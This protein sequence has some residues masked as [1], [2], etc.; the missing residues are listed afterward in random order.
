MAP[1]KA[2]E[3]VILVIGNAGGDG[4][5]SVLTPHGLVHVPGNNPLMREALAVL[6]KSYAKVQEIA[7]KQQAG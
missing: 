7:E 2:T 4:G 6:L 5:S 1:I 3:E